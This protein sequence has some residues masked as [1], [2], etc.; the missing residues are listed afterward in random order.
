MVSVEGLCAA[1]SVC[2]CVCLG[3]CVSGCVEASASGSAGCIHRPCCPL[4]LLQGL[5]CIR[6]HTNSV[7]H[8]HNGSDRQAPGCPHPFLHTQSAGGAGGL[9]MFL[10]SHQGSVDVSRVL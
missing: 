1:C 6:G 8:C 4:K 2:V 10:H 3:V 9:G 7:L 5:S